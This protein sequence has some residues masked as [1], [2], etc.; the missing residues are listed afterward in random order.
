ITAATSSISALKTDSG[1]FST[2]VTD[3][4]ATGSIL[5]G[6][7]N[8]QGLG[9]T[10][11]PTFADLTA[12]GT[13][14]AQEFH[15]EFVS[16]S[17]VYTSGS[18][19]FGDTSDDVHQFTGSL[20]VTG[21][22]DHYFTDGNVGIGTTDPLDPLYVVGD[23]SG[24][25]AVSNLMTLYALLGTDGGVGGGASIKFALRGADVETPIASIG[26]VSTA[27][28]GE[29]VSTDADFFINLTDGG[30]SVERF[31]VTSDGNVGI[32]NTIPNNTLD[33]RLANADGLST[34]TTITDM[35]VPGLAIGARNT[36]NAVD[37]ILTG[38]RF[39]AFNGEAAIG[40]TYDAANNSS[41]VFGTENGDGNIT[42]RMRIISTG[43][44]GI[45][46][47][48]PATV[49][50]VKGTANNEVLQL[51]AMDGDKMLYFNTASS[52]PYMDIFADG[53][54]TIDFRLNTNGDSWLNGGDVGIG[55]T[56]PAAA[57]QVVG[58]I[59]VDSDAGG[60]AVR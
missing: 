16:A 56:N 55:T 18:T 34:V 41:L 7:G 23:F 44:V 60:S 32:G 40:A 38:I 22:G 15:T 53:G 48:A 43:N 42:E 28:D 33:V 10:N 17:I 46:S 54:S 58:S 9:S 19:K 11:S 49:L 39:E 6:S 35:D 57:L 59:F 14:T 24:G 21:S 31:R 8:I 51:T 27:A 36:Q 25:A 37:A 47:A 26:A 4:N 45:G 29:V 50:D 3:N 13:V 52:Q 20:R 5:A 1:S 2:R 12:T 30:S